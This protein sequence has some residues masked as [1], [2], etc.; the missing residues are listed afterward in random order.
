MLISE[1]EVKSEKNIKQENEKQKSMYPF[2]LLSSFRRRVV[3]CLG[4]V[5][6]VQP[7]HTA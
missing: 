2:Y 3:V 1:N 4:H 5:I 7:A 6:N